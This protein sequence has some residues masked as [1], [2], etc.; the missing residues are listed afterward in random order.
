MEFFLMGGRRSD[1]SA[2]GS[3]ICQIYHNHGTKV[4]LY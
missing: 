2:S 3:G 1:L 4:A